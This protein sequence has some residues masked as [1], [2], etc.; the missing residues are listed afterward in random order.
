MSSNEYESSSNTSETDSSMDF[1]IPAGKQPLLVNRPRPDEIKASEVPANTGSDIA[2]KPANEES[3][4]VEFLNDSEF[5]G[6]QEQVSTFTCEVTQIPQECTP[7]CQKKRKSTKK[8]GKVTGSPLST[9]SEAGKPEILGK[10][11]PTRTPCCGLS[12]GGGEG[13]CA[14]HAGD[15]GAHRCPRLGVWG[16][17]GGTRPGRQTNRVANQRPGIRQVFSP[18][19]RLGSHLLEIN[20]RCVQDVLATTPRNQILTSGPTGFFSRTTWKCRSSNL[21]Y[22]K[23]ALCSVLKTPDSSFC[24]MQKSRARD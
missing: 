14:R 10:R 9:D 6:P 12:G 4:I 2:E 22:R 21:Y 5:L 13:L 18:R 1:E 24:L 19:S 3:D 15:P 17:G 16:F 23:P 8:T 7:V 20:M 11:R